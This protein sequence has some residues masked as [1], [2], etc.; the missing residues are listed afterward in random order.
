MEKFRMVEVKRLKKMNKGEAYDTVLAELNDLVRFYFRYGVV[1]AGRA[2]Q[3]AIFDRMKDQKNY[4]RYIKHAL[5]EESNPFPDGFNFILAE[6]IQRFG[7]EAT[8][9][10]ELADVCLIY[11]DVLEKICKSH[12]KHI[13]KD[14]DVPKDIAMEI[15]I[16]YPGTV[17]SKH[18]AWVFA[19]QLNRRLMSLQKKCCPIEVAVTKTTEETTKEDADSKVVAKP[20]VKQEEDLTFSRFDFADKRFIKNLFKGYYG[21]DEE[22]LERVYGSLMLDRQS[23]TMHYNE[24]QKRLWSAMTEVMLAGIEKLPIKIVKNIAENYVRRRNRDAEHGRENDPQRRVVVQNLEFD[25]SPKLVTVFNPDEYSIKDALKHD[26]KKSKKGK[27]KD[28]KKK[29]H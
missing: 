2:E 5:K 13:S 19:S 9:N 14:L 18:N 12:A 21:K 7:R 1:A 22:V 28:K 27:K 16:I 4:A 6:F 3:T 17:L 11:S 26:G 25:K 24:S 20:V 10:D 15:A 23:M 29:K 8:T